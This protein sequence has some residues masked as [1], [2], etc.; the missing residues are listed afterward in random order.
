[1]LERIFEFLQRERVVLRQRRDEA[2]QEAQT[3]VGSMPAGEPYH[4]MLVCFSGLKEV[5]P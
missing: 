4:A 3:S 5:I 2:L 1:M